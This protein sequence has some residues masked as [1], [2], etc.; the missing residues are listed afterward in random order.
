ML[1]DA[2]V[3]NFPAALGQNIHKTVPVELQKALHCAATGADRLEGNGWNVY[4]FSKALWTSMISIGQYRKFVDT[5]GMPL[6][7][8]LIL[9]SPSCL[10]GPE[11]ARRWKHGLV[12]YLRQKM[13]IRVGSS[14]AF[15]HLPAYS[16]IIDIVVNLL[17]SLP[18]SF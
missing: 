7:I 6:K 8:L 12:L 15:H 18:L 3:I 16:K 10:P 2:P 5:L 11:T 9:G 1:A 17:S 14:P 4:T 13:N